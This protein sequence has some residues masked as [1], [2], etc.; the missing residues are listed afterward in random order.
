M[1]YGMP[2]FCLVRGSNG[3]VPTWISGSVHKARRHSGD[4]LSAD[5]KEFQEK[6]DNP[7]KL[8]GGDVTS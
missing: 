4:F 5:N 6:A 2:N 8:C 1:N 7:P 3:E